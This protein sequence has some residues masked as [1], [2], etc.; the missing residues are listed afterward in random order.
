MHTIAC[1]A[2]CWISRSS[3]LVSMGRT[4]S[5]YPQVTRDR[6]VMLVRV[7]EGSAI[8]RHL[9]MLLTSR[10]KP[11]ERPGAPGPIFERDHDLPA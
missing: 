9:P 2:R 1:S 3:N 10:E 4:S 8:M 6:A 11:L 7:C 5:L